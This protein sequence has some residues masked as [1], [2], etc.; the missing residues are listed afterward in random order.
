MSNVCPHAGEKRLVRVT[1]EEL[2][3]DAAVTAQLCRPQTVHSVNNAQRLPIHEDRWPA[4]PGLGQNGDVVKVFAIESWRVPG[5]QC[6]AENCLPAPLVQY[7]PGARSFAAGWFFRD[8][9]LN[10]IR[11]VTA[12]NRCHLP[13]ENPVR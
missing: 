7:T 1:I 9:L 6:P 2:N 3:F 12:T 4:S 11:H 8:D 10:H 13:L 5:L